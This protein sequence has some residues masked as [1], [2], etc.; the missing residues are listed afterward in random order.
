MLPNFGKSKI[1]LNRYGKIKRNTQDRGGGKGTPNKL[2][3]NMKEWLNKF[4]LENREQIK[5]D[6]MLLQP[7][8]RLF[9]Y[10]KLLAYII[11]KANNVDITE[12]ETE[13]QIT[14]RYIDAGMECAS[15]EEEVRKREGLI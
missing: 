10:E 1:E 6:F 5:K 13:N 2:N 3:G 9:L 15:S 8:E 12:S 14:I 7:K 4:L 11:P